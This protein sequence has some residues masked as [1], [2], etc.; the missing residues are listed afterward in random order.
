M[1]KSKYLAGICCMLVSGLLVEASPLEIAQLERQIVSHTQVLYT[2]RTQ[3]FM[4]LKNLQINAQRNNRDEEKFIKGWFELAE[5]Y[6]AAV[7]GH[8]KLYAMELYGYMERRLARKSSWNNRT[9][10]S[11]VLKSLRKKAKHA[12]FPI[13]KR[14]FKMINKLT[15]ARQNS[16]KYFPLVWEVANA[17]VNLLHVAVDEELAQGAVAWNDLSATQLQQISTLLPRLLRLSNALAKADEKGL[18]TVVEGLQQDPIVIND[19]KTSLDLGKFLARYGRYANIQADGVGMAN[20][21]AKMV[22]LAQ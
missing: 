9:V 15:E 14:C 16:R 19:G 18:K 3:F 10:I 13:Q 21:G 17:R 7:E 8:S 6:D 20:M 4:A 1:K 11:Y 22:A 2:V 5:K 12:E